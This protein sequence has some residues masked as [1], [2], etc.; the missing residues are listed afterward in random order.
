MTVEDQRLGR[1]SRLIRRDARLRQTDLPTSRF[2]T[3][4]IEAGRAGALRLDDLRTHFAA[5]GAKAQLTV[6][7]NGAA[8]DRLVDRA[9]AQIVEAAAVVLT[10]SGFRVRVEHSFNDYGER[11][12][13]D[14]FAGHDQ[15]RAVFVGEA[16]SEWGSLEETLRRQDMKVRLAAK[17][18]HEAFGWRPRIVA[19]VLVLPDDSTSRRVVQRHN[20]TLHAYAMR[21]RDIRAWMHR[22]DR[23][24]AGIWFLSNAA[25]VRHE[26]S[27]TGESGVSRSTG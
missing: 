8:L 19:N 24:I 9:H 23:S 26:S 14:L 4:E 10:R 5:M 7:W 25:L 12:S 17:L 21:A 3:Q 16:K 20:A 13:I 2:V 22:P 15:A 1:A 18:A 11:G 6:W 27:E